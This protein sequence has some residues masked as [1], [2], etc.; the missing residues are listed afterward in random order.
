MTDRT[1]R[2]LW[3]IVTLLVCG[4]LLVGCGKPGD[5]AARA[6]QQGLSDVP[7]GGDVAPDFIIPLLDGSSLQLSDLRGQPVVLYFWATWCGSCTFDMPII[8]GVYREQMGAGLTILTVNVGQSQAEVQRF[9][10]EGEYQIPF[11][12]DGGMDIGRAYRLLGF[13]S[14][15]FID[16]AGQIQHV[17][18]GPISREGFLEQL[19]QITISP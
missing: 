14:T 16:R 1:K 17:R 6:A 4:L 3:L 9:V 8:D 18:V 19:A 13:P 15:Y 7:G 12:L 11:G 5:V 2:N 10:D